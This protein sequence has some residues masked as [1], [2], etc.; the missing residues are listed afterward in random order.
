MGTRIEPM[1]AWLHCHSG[2]RLLP[3]SSISKA[4]AAEGI[5]T[6]WRSD[7][8][9]P[10]LGIV[11]F[12]EETPDLLE[13]LEK[14]T[15]RGQ[16][17]VL[18][19][20]VQ[21]SA[22]TGNRPWKLMQA[23]ASDV[24]A[25]DGTAAPAA[26]IA[27]RLAR[28]KAVDDLV[29]SPLVQDN[30]AGH[31]RAWVMALRQVIEL[32]RFTDASVL[33][34]GES[35]T[36]KEL[37]ARLIHTLDA[38]DQK[39]EFVVLDCTTVVPELSGSE[40]F[41]HERGAFTHAVASRDGAFAIADGGSLFLDEVGEL[42]LPLQAELLR[43]VQERTYKRIGSNHWKNVNF[44]LI[45]A[46]NRNLQDEQARGA[47]R[48]DFYHR[49]ASWT[50]H[51]PPLRERREDIIP[52]TV[53]FLRQLYPSGDA[54]GLDAAVRDYL[55]L[56]EYPG[57]VR[58]LRQLVM[59]MAKRHVGPGPITVGDIPEDENPFAVEMMR[60]D[61]R[62]SNFQTAIRHALAM[63][64]TL[65]QI[66]N[67][68]TEVAIRIALEDEMGNLQQAARKLGVTDRALQ[69]R[70]ASQRERVEDVIDSPGILEAKPKSPRDHSDQ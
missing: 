9:A 41:G 29:H 42:P 23:G 7:Q 28:W 56:R 6:G 68:A 36:G 30:L 38:R 11:F 24:M 5:S 32:A 46:T 17:R 51:L 70:R 53:H 60:S 58:D 35:G 63:G 19:I 54:P 10:N 34:T 3:R 61:W 31:S 39:R 33:I 12:N 47:F 14:S 65:K 45:C 25:W 13:F 49:I 15:G 62:G 48:L 67:S 37:V 52:L 26:A 44:R 18:A 27:A 69:I 66:S 1:S 2:E 43:I 55:L 59:R 22:V 57:N 4:L 16:A 40:F 21:K 20:A 8:F 50:C 64:V